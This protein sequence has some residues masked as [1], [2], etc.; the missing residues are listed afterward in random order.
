MA[1]SHKPVLL[2]DIINNL[3][4]L[5][6]TKPIVNIL[7]ATFGEG[8]S[9]N[10]LE[11]KNRG[12]GFNV[13][14]NLDM[15]MSGDVN[16]FLKI[17]QQY[18]REFLKADFEEKSSV[19]D[20]NLTAE[21]ILN[22]FSENDIAD[23][24]YLYG[25]EK[26]SRVIAREI[27]R[28]RKENPLTTTYQLKNVVEKAI[29]WRRKGVHPATK[30]FQALRIYINKELQEIQAGINFSLQNLTANGYLFM[31][32]FHS[33]E[34]RIIKKNF[35]CYEK[36]EYVLILIEFEGDLIVR[37]EPL[38]KILTKKPITPSL[39]ELEL[40]PR[41]RS[42]KLRIAQKNGEM[43]IE[44]HLLFDKKLSEEADVGFDLFKKDSV[45]KKK[46]RELRKGN[47]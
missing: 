19:I 45:L 3:K 7:D 13:D 20:N 2:H 31:V 41:S 32:S 9:Q 35:K 43:H 24:L 6:L 40:N 22:T 30:T 17:F 46:I 8:T 10:Q 33:L 38:L 1:F 47:F 37:G 23:I 21:S 11:D 44:E 4:T 27:Y 39:A 29:G 34:D 18:N 5:Q 15:R 14:G 25:E 16:Q 12:F 26:N 42:A 36:L 28:A